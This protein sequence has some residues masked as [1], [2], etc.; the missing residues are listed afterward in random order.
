LGAA[1]P[2]STT[3]PPSA[4]G[5]AQPTSF[6]VDADLE[7]N[8]SHPDQDQINTL[9]RG[10]SE[11]ITASCEIPQK[12]GSLLIFSPSYDHHFLFFFFFLL[13][14]DFDVISQSSCIWSF[15]WGGNCNISY[16]IPRDTL[17]LTIWRAQ[18]GKGIFMVV[19]L[20]TENTQRDHGLE[21]GKRRLDS[22]LFIHDNS[23]MFP[24]LPLSDHIRF[25]CLC[26]SMS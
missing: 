19:S 8:P 10:R 24:S 15:L 9:L 18:S 6:L 25:L 1:C 4:P 22:I 17:C 16:Y 14:N 21:P 3:G 11:H 13:L 23:F 26:S 5:S 7:H 2:G 20:G 12:L